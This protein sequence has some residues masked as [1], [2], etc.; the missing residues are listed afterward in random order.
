MSEQSL[1]QREVIMITPEGNGFKEKVNPIKPNEKEI[2]FFKC[3]CKNP[4]FRHAGYMQTMVPFIRPGDERR[5]SV[6][7]RQ[8]MVCTKCKNCYVWINEQMYDVTHMI[9][10]KAWEKTEKDL[11]D[12]TGPGGQC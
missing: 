12:T 2:F 9:D 11:H 4:H 7:N 1:E 5:M 8:V 6:D 3:E 10:I